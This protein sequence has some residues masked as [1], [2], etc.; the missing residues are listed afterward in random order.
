M[1]EKLKDFYNKRKT[2]VMLIILAAAVALPFVVSKGS[3]MS[4][5][6]RIMFYVILASSLNIINGYSGQFNIGHAGFVLIGSYT[7]SIL[8][9]SGWP[10]WLLFV[11]SGIVSS[12]VG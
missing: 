1:I 11:V 7:L 3:V 2:I 9:Q 4:L 10:I 8:A 6:V 12:I 5:I